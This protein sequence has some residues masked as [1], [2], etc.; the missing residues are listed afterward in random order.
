MKQTDAVISGTGLFT[1]EESVSNDELVTAFNA[2]VDLF[3]EEHSEAI[4]KGEVEARTYSSTA[5]IEKASG[6][7]SRYVLNKSGIIDPQRMAPQLAER[8]NSELSVMAEIGVKAARQ[9]L[10]AA[11]L[12]ASDLDAVIV[13]ASNMQR[14]Y[15]AMAVEIQ[16]ALGAK[17][18][19]FDM[20]VACSSAT[21]G[22]QQ[23]RDSIRAGSARRILMV[24][25]EICTGH[26]NFRDRDAHFIFGDVA[27]AVVIEAT[28][29][30]RATSN[31]EIIDT[32]LQTIFSNNIRNNFGFM[33]RADE[34]GIGAVDKLFVQEGRKVFKEVCPA[35]A[36]QINEQLA[37]LNLQADQLSRLWLHQANR[38]MNDLIAR[39][40]L[41]R[42]PTEKESPTIL[43]AYAN[44]SSAGS[45]IAFHL[46]RDDLNA[47]EL[48]V[49][50]SFGAGY[51]IGSVVL[52]AT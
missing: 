17:G 41:G 26:L 33:N 16:D 23:A 8:P 46:N 36:Q 5:F 39:R 35:V 6:I 25:P 52:R 12:D 4:A 20:N 31:F 49:L 28:D 37:D 48:G 3:N 44:T 51:S 22:I 1:P 13:A 32:R 15:P 40:V 42:E 43:D 14:A 10:E 9:A 38:N 27:T 24:N 19:A 18:F 2:W 34:R 29:V 45:I 21:F 30:V 7:K 50:C 11:D 47:G